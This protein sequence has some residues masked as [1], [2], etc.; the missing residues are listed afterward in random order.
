[1]QALVAL[2]WGERADEVSVVAE[3]SG[4]KPWRVTGPGA[5]GRRQPPAAVLGACRETG[6]LCGPPRVCVHL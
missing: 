2:G 4:A 3:L 1:M 5:E 6:V